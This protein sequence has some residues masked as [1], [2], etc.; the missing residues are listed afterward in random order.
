MRVTDV[1]N[2]PNAM[3]VIDT[4]FVDLDALLPGDDFIA[5]T[6]YSSYLR[7]FTATLSFRVYCAVGYDGPT[8]NKI[9]NA[10]IQEG[11]F[12]CNQ[13]GDLICLHGYHNL[14][15]NCTECVPKDGCCK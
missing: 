5:P 8:C 13:D 4:L 6:S 15:I 1:D 11:N 10:N 14:S 9:C 2:S 3:Q 7:Y 12:M